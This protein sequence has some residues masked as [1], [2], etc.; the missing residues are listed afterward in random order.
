[1]EH[2]ELSTIKDWHMQVEELSQGLITSAFLE[3]EYISGNRDEL[4]IQA[5]IIY[6]LYLDRV[7]IWK[8]F[9]I[10]NIIE[11]IQDYDEEI[12]EQMADIVMNNA[13]IDYSKTSHDTYG[14]M[15]ADVIRELSETYQTYVWIEFPMTGLDSIPFFVSHELQKRGAY[16]EILYPAAGSWQAYQGVAKRTIGYNDAQNILF[17]ELIGYDNMWDHLKEDSVEVPII[18]RPYYPANQKTLGG[19]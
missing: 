18:V 4:L 5:D 13:D 11:D 1:M 19:V 3:F 7:S 14:D 15:R 6:K 10:E 2:K 9:F 12:L 16:H 8:D 17:P